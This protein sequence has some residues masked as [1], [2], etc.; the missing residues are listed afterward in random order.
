ML[1]FSSDTILKTDFLIYLQSFTEC[2][3]CNGCCY[4]EWN[5][6]AKFKLQSSLLYPLQTNIIR[7][8]IS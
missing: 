8:D 3:M 6:Q 1:I 5:Q 7:K 2:S 4:D